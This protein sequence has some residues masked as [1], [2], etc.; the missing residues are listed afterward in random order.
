ML[1][2]QPPSA[3][4]HLGGNGGFPVAVAGPGL[5]ALLWGSLTS[6][7]GLPAEPE[8]KA[9]CQGP[10]SNRHHGQEATRVKGGCAASLSHTDA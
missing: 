2:L 10:D 6:S 4:A 5:C 9:A 7:L 3:F 8:P 1:T